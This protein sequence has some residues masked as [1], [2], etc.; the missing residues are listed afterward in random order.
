MQK[1]VYEIKFNLDKIAENKNLSAA[2]IAKLCRLS[3]QTIWGLLSGQVS[4]SIPTLN[5]IANGLQV[6][7]MSLWR[8][9]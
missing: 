8:L 5:K 6:D 9:E 2:Q 1:Q 3:R 7:P 4:P